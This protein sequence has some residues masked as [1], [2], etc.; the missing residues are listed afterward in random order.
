MQFIWE[1]A[2]ITCTRLNRTH[3]PGM[4]HVPVI[5]ESGDGGR[6]T[7]SL[8]LP[9]ASKRS[10]ASLGYIGACLKN[11]KI[12]YYDFGIVMLYLSN[13]YYD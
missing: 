5:P 1:S 4:W 2:S 10:K 13:K 6:R 11:I 9:S 12:L 3:K 8:K 7:R